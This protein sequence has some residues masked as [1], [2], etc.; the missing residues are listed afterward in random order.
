[1]AA[2][3]PVLATVTQITANMALSMPDDPAMAMP[4]VKLGIWSPARDFKV[5]DK[6]T[7]HWH[8]SPS[9]GGWYPIH[10]GA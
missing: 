3:S 1:M 10:R 9:R 6:V 5:G 7:L 2:H 4:S 8:S